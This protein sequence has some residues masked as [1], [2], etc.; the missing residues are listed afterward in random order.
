MRPSVKH[1]L[2]LLFLLVAT[3]ASAQI[4]CPSGFATSGSCG[5]GINTFGNT[6]WSGGSPGSWSSTLV[7]SQLALAQTGASHTAISMLYQTKVNVQG[8]STSFNFVPNG[9]Y[10]AFVAEN[11]NNSYYGLNGNGF[12]SGA[13]NEGGFYQAFPGGPPLAPVNNVFAL[14]FDQYNGINHTAAFNYTYN[15]LTPYQTG[16]CP[17][18]LPSVGCGGTYFSDYELNKLSMSPLPMSLNWNPTDAN[19]SVP[20]GCAPGDP[21]CR[22]SPVGALFTGSISGNILTV[23][24]PLGNSFIRVGQTLTHNS[25]AD[26]T[27][28]VNQLAG[29]TGGAGTYTLSNSLGTVGAATMRTV[30]TFSAQLSYDGYVLSACIYDVTA[31][32]GSCSSSTS[33]TGTFFTHTWTGVN[34]PGIVGATTAWVGFTQSTSTYTPTT[35]LYLNSFVYSSASPA[36]SHSFTSTNYVTSTTTQLAAPSFSPAAGSYTGT[37]NVSLSSSAN[38]V[39]CYAVGAGSTLPAI[40]PQPNNVGGCNSGTLYTG[41]ISVASTSTVYASAGPTAAAL[42]YGSGILGVPSTVVAAAYNIGGGTP[43]AATPTFS[44]AAGTYTSTQTVT[45]SDTTPASTIHYTTDGSTPT[46]GSATY[47]APLTVAAT[48]TVK[49]IAVASGYLQS[50]VGSVLYTIT[51]SCAVPS[52]SP[53]GGTYATTQS[54]TMTDSTGGCS[55]YYTTNGTTP[56]T[57]STPYTG[58]VSVSTT[59]TL[60]AIAAQSGYTTSGVQSQTYTISPILATP[61]FSPVGGTYTGAQTVSISYPSGSNACVGINTTPT[62]PTAGTCG[63]GGTLYT[64]PITVSASETL[65]VIA[66]RAGFTNSALGVAA[67]TINPVTPQTCTFTGTVTLQ[68]TVKPQ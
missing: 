58:A 54:V 10:L 32:N 37:Q 3:V 50:A 41:P 63:S 33:G 47:T 5:V 64:G 46:T 66:T 15:T 7:G 25:T 22:N 18:S 8:F 28:I 56:T 39:I 44:P 30:D 24:S 55:I 2:A 42:V 4:N 60:K 51:L 31:A 29:T 34:I 48:T 21:L 11:S 59:T 43:T 13:G 17:Q 53:S 20:P 52:F 19:Y 38:S 16:Q 57:G 36:T 14:E 6:F 62:A 12:S 26:G 61:T 1:Y 40:L 9:Q 65:N 49:A 67:Y 35:P 23:S 27:T 45:L 68:G